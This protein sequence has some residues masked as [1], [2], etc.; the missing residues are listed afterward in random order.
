VSSLPAELVRISPSEI[1]I[2]E[3][4]SNIPN[5]LSALQPYFVNVIPSK[6]APIPTRHHHDTHHAN[7]KNREHLINHIFNND[8]SILNSF[9]QNE[10]NVLSGSWLDDSYFISVLN[11]RS[12]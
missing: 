4:V 3:A 10:Y 12:D 6:K 5:L 11:D 9:S 2:S 8:L 7:E 1:L